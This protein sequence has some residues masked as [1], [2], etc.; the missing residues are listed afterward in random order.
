MRGSRYLPTPSTWWCGVA[1]DAQAMVLGALVLGVLFMVTVLS[2]ERAGVAPLPDVPEA[3]TRMVQEGFA[4][5]LGQM[6]ATGAGGPPPATQCADLTDNDLDGRADMN[7]PGCSSPAGN[8]EINPACMDGLD[9]DGDGFADRA[10]TVAFPPDPGCSS[11]A[12]TSEGPAFACSNGLDD[13]S[14][15]FFDFPADPHC[16]DRADNSEGP[17]Q[18]S[19]GVDNDLDGRTDFSLNPFTTD[20]GCV[21]DMDVSEFPNPQCSDGVDNDGDLLA[22]FP[23]DP[24][25]DAYQDTRETG[26]T[27]GAGNVAACADGFDNDGDGRV[28]LADS[29]CANAAD[30]SEL[31]DPACDDRVDND[32]DGLAD[33]PNDPGCSPFGVSE[34]NAACSNVAEVGAVVGDD[35]GD[36][37]VDYP[38]DSGCDS[39]SDSTEAATYQCGNGIDDDGD[40]F[41]DYPADPQCVDA[42]DND[43]TGPMGPPPPP[44][45]APEYTAATLDA[46]S[47]QLRQILAQHGWHATITWTC[48]LP[49]LVVQARLVGPVTA[50]RAYTY[51]VV[52]CPA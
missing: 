24:G 49:D 15:T 42:L 38:A 36:G 16:Q 51:P 34:A 31:G 41:V 39:I 1:D 11:A 33:Y 45:P 48:N 13:D 14:D 18:C 6:G 21:D 35:D 43:E 46:L 37:A 20:H 40:T 44:P 9:N 50:D 10:G 52:A 17:P 5:L 26:L 7:D 3:P 47:L 28:D 30:T 4:H 19:D 25:C 32:G 12:D 29:G 2:A 22:D 8:S 23:A 27:P